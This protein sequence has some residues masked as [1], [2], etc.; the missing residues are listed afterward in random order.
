MYDYNNKPELNITPLVDV[1]LVLLAILMVTAPVIE[2][3]EKI[4]LP[5]GSHSSKLSQTK[6]IDILMTKDGKILVNKSPIKMIDFADSFV[7]YAKDKSRDIPVHIRADKN[8]KYDNVIF[9]LKTIKETG[10]LKV[11]L[12]TDG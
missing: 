4:N 7:L 9:I 2:Y 8:L 12:I 3:E 1:M 11:A 10:F 6:K 5:R